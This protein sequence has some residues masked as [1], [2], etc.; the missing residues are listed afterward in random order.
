MKGYLENEID[1]LNPS[2]GENSDF[3]SDSEIHPI[4]M[5]S[6]GQYQKGKITSENSM[7]K[8]PIQVCIIGRPNVG[9]STLVNSLLKEN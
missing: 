2:P 5:I 1:R 8:K 9:K 3:D 4:D 7:K 6:V